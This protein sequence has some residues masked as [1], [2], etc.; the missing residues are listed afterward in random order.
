M[1][2]AGARQARLDLIADTLDAHL[3]VARLFAIIE[4]G[5]VRTERVPTP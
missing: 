5:A 3:D 2:F 4:Q 1:S